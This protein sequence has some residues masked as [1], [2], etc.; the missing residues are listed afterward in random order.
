[1]K[2]RFYKNKEVIAKIGLMIALTMTVCTYN[3][4]KN[5]VHADTTSISTSASHEDNF[6]YLSDLSYSD[7]KSGW[8]PIQINK[9]IREKKISL[10]IGQSNVLFNKGIG[11]HAPGYVEYDVSQ[12]VSEGYNKLSGFAGMDT[13]SGQ[14]DGAGLEIYLY[15]NGG[16][17]LAFST[18]KLYPS[19]SAKS[20][21]LDLEGVSK[22]KFVTLSMG[23]NGADH[24][25]FAN[26]KLY[27]SGETAAGK[28]DPVAQGPTS[29][30]FKTEE[31]YYNI[32][33]KDIPNVSSFDINSASESVKKDILEAEL[34]RR[35]GFN[36]NAF[37]SID[38]A[39]ARGLN[40]LENNQSLLELFL[41]GGKPDGSYS[42]ALK[43]LGRLYDKYGADINDPQNGKLY[44]KMMAAIS[45]THSTTVKLWTNS[46]QPSDPLVRYKMF[47][48]LYTEGK[49]INS[50]MFKNLNVDLMR[51]IVGAQIDDEEI[52]W[53]NSYVRRRSGD[54]ALKLN[55]YDYIT[56]NMRFNYNKPEFYDPEKK[57]QWNE[58][59]GIDGLSYGISGNNK[60]WMV[61]ESGAVCGGI[62]KTGTNIRQVFG[63]P[64]TVIGQPGHAAYLIY[65]ESNG[66]GTW[67]IGNNIYGFAKSEKGERMPLDWPGV[68][69]TR[70]YTRDKYMVNYIFIIQAAL[71]DKENL[72]KAQ[73]Y[74]MLGEVFFKNDDL[75]N[76]Q[77][78]FKKGL[79]VQKINIDSLMGLLRSYKMD[80]DTTD[81]NY[82][83]MADLVLENYK[84]FPMPMSDMLFQIN[85]NFKNNVLKTEYDMKEYAALNAAKDM[86][87]NQYIQANFAREEAK[88]LLGDKKNDPLA[89]FSFDGD[90]AD[91][92]IINPKY[93]AYGIR[94]RYSLDGGKT[95]KE[96]NE[97]EI[98]LSPEEIK[99]ITADNNIIVGL[100]GTNE[101]YTIDIVPG[102]STRDKVYLNDKEDRVYGDL[103]GL[104]Y[105]LDE[106]ET[107]HNYDASKDGTDFGPE[108][109]NVEFKYAARGN[110]LEGPVTI[111]RL[112]ADANDGYVKLKHLTLESVSSEQG[113]TK[114][115]LLD[116]MFDNIWHSK[117][118]GDD[119][120]EVVIKM[121]HPRF[122]KKVDLYVRSDS[123]NG[124]PKDVSIFVSNDGQ[125]W[126]DAVAEVNNFPDNANMKTIDIQNPKLGSYIMIKA[127]HTYGHTSGEIDKFFTLKEV[128][129]YENKD[130]LK[131]EMA[132][133][134]SIDYSNRDLTNQDVVAT[135]NLPEGYTVEGDKTHTFTE[136]GK[137]TFKYK[138]NLGQEHTKDAEV[139]WIDKVLPTAEVVY[140]KTTET[141]GDVCASLTNFNKEGITVTNMPVGENGKQAQCYTFNENGEFE[142]NLVDKAGNTNKIKAVVT[143]IKS[144][145]EKYVEK[146]VVDAEIAKYEAIKSSDLY[147]K[148]D[149]EQKTRFDSELEKLKAINTET[150][151]KKSDYDAVVTQLESAKNLLNGKEKVKAELE[152]LLETCTNMINDP[153]FSKVKEGDKYTFACSCARNVCGNKEVTVEALED[154]ISKL[155]IVK[156]DL[157]SEF[158][159]INNEASVEANK[160]A[161]NTDASKPS[162]GE[163]NTSND[164]THETN[165]EEVTHPEKTPEVSESTQPSNTTSES[166]KDDSS[167]TGGSKN[168]S[169]HPENKPTETGKEEVT[170]PEKQPVVNEG[171]HSDNKPIE[172]EATGIT[173]PE[174]QPVVNEG[175]HSDN[176]PIE[177][178]ATEITHP[179]KTPAVSET[180]HPGN[181]PSET[182]KDNTPSGSQ[183]SPST[184]SE[185]PKTDRDA[186][187]VPPKDATTPGNT[188]ANKESEKTNTTA[189]EENVKPEKTNPSVGNTANNVGEN[190]VNNIPSSDVGNNSSVAVENVSPQPKIDR[191]S[192]GTNSVEYLLKS[193]IDKTATILDNVIS[194]DRK[195]YRISGSNRYDTSIEISKRYFKHADHVV[196][197][198]GNNEADALSSSLYSKMLKGP[199]LLSNTTSVDNSLLKELERLGCK[200]ITIV[201]G[202]NSISDKVV[203][204]LKEKGYEINRISGKNRVETSKMIVEDIL[205]KTKAKTIIVANPDSMADSLAVSYMSNKKDIPLLLSNNVDE[206][207]NLIKTYG[208]KKVII[209]GGVN[210]DNEKIDSEQVQIIKGKDRYDTSKQIYDN[211]N[212]GKNSNIV[213]ANGK[214][215]IDALSYGAVSYL[216]DAPILLVEKNNLPSS[217]KD[218]IKDSEGNIIILG[219][220]NTIK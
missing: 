51:W 112:S 201:G 183:V 30:N 125:N 124:R 80:P 155:K 149:Q 190:T 47:K 99:E 71:D 138:D 218:T 204:Q 184:D 174:K 58:K 49:L 173:H 143:W 25:E 133:N 54:S 114:K 1:M 113:D 121:D 181:N 73:Y 95:F 156:S 214:N 72:L 140:D 187:V 21:D 219:G 65:S 118:S 52:P 207:N 15:K 84:N 92:I 109:R 132:K 111:K 36:L 123:Q 76:A 87:N 189:T 215:S 136:N 7:S 79:D 128:E 120:R 29:V 82:K 23:N 194:K 27:K 176:K 185:G 103:R 127:N 169:T 33:K 50:D 70:S 53:L 34:T 146:S 198:S 86:P 117:Y 55:P 192:I 206:I 182:G 91:T 9:S 172:S 85:R 6:K 188:T 68:W 199:T 38:P 28:E 16:Y 144:N 134:V 2:G 26:V 10:R 216:Q 106:G 100:V 139:K 119:K 130:M 78:S 217:V 35:I 145:K 209:V 93:K 177:S 83:E 12:Y 208:L 60:L 64:A 97:Y 131:D 129:L 75:K 59:Y 178:E 14:S 40:V 19:L 220:E 105:S 63:E 108:E 57:A 126:G 67:S 186:N 175:I 48:D 163:E 77:A 18:G 202:Q 90:K 150:N 17:E 210:I 166:G 205:N 153:R 46:T 89:T 148:S 180:T 11:I 20:F 96:S 37:A 98:K 115:Y 42:E 102:E 81:E 193:D 110:M 61:F 69:N 66:K 167:H 41:T 211:L 154:N 170:H 203:D 8:G 39:I 151:I 5:E 45:L 22:I 159:R 122:I 161:N 200:K 164:K 101:T 171:T 197:A 4:I 24:T 212:V 162:T 195:I 141:D 44:E 43:V 191:P 62:S 31:E 196:I 213:L 3:G 147:K 160:E 179:E 135:L 94:V 137:F 32:L 107:W 142:F 168:E 74:N 158:V 56:Y 157:E 13:E 152:D 104:M 88:Y 165:K 116:G